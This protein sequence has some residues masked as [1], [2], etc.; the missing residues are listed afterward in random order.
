MRLG[1][2]KAAPNRQAFQTKVVV[3]WCLIGENF[4]TRDRI[5]GNNDESSLQYF[6]GFVLF[7]ARVPF[8]PLNENVDAQVDH[9]LNTMLSR[10]LHWIEIAVN[11]SEG[12]PT[13]IRGDH[14]NHQ[15]CI[16]TKV[17]SKVLLRLTLCKCARDSRSQALYSCASS[18]LTLS[19]VAASAWVASRSA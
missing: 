3:Y 12:R 11:D 6:A 17:S 8:A 16:P 10:M 1:A 15:K 14:S 9:I 4:G 13:M 19:S 18:S 2:K 5:G 7:F